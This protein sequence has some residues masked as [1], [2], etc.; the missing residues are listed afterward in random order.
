MTGRAAA[1]SIQGVHP[2]RSFLLSNPILAL[3]VGLAALALR[4]AVPA[5]FM[6]ASDQGRFVL[7]P[8][9]GAGTEPSGP[10]RDMHPGKGS[11]EAQ[12]SCAFADLSLPATGGTGA[13]SVSV[14]P[15]YAAVAAPFPGAMPPE[16]SEL[17]L[18]PPLRGPPLPL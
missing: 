14:P 4:L 5:G 9:G 8:C 15:V 7:A 6:P 13:V 12:A 3:A 1:I 17:R 2:V 10:M 16:R 18:R 11:A